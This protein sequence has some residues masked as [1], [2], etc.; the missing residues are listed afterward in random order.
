MVYCAQRS[1]LLSNLLFHH[2]GRWLSDMHVDPATGGKSSCFPVVC[3]PNGQRQTIERRFVIMVH[4]LKPASMFERRCL[5][6]GDLNDILKQRTV[7]WDLR[8]ERG[9]KERMEAIPSLE[10]AGC[11]DVQRGAWDSHASVCFFGTA[12]ILPCLFHNFCLKIL[13]LIQKLWSSYD[14]L[15]PPSSNVTIYMAVAQCQSLETD[16]GKYHWVDCRPIQDIMGFIR[17]HCGCQE[18]DRCIV[19]VCGFLSFKFT[20]LITSGTSDLFIHQL[21]I[22]CVVILPCILKTQNG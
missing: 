13:I 6:A 10:V 20:L 3:I 8:T 5:G 9:Q 19:Q 12:N 14:T 17:M 2:G 16:L 1:M 15:L 18:C 4:V 11:G 22:Y 7:S 21:T